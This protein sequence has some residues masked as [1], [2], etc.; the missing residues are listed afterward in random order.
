MSQVF[1]IA[2]FYKKGG[3][4]MR[5]KIKGQ[6]CGYDPAAKRDRD[7]IARSNRRCAAGYGSTDLSEYTDTIKGITT[8]PQGHLL[9]SHY[10]DFEQVHIASQAKSNQWRESATTKKGS[11]TMKAIKKATTTTNA[12]INSSAGKIPTLGEVAKS[13][14]KASEP[15][16]SAP[17]K[18]AKPVRAKR[19]TVADVSARVATLERSMAALTEAVSAMAVS[20]AKLTDTVNKAASAP[21]NSPA[22]VRRATATAKSAPD[23]AIKAAASARK[24]AKATIQP[25]AGAVSITWVSEVVMPYGTIKVG[26]FVRSDNG[27]VRYAVTADERIPGLT[28]ELKP[29]KLYWSKFAMAYIGK[30][31]P[32]AEFVK[33]GG[34]VSKAAKQA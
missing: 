30:A 12:T 7:T 11:T 1:L 5:V 26:S 10:S 13:T 33:L 9:Y 23:K 19:E 3:Y 14:Y 25:K 20:M 29:L 21:V 27:E 22:P 2:I 8:N 6:P 31:D 34:K 17:T 28:A 32:T 16:K 4:H 24:A 18:A 15:T